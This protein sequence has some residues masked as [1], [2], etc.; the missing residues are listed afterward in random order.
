MILDRDLMNDL[1]IVL[2]FDSKS[3]E[4]D[5]SVVAKREH[6]INM[7]TNSF[8]NNLLLDAIDGSLD[9]NDSTL[10]W[11]NLPTSITKLTTPIQMDINQKLFLHLSMNRPTYRILWIKA[12]IFCHNNANNSITCCR[13]FINCLMVN[14][15]PS[16]ALRSI[17]SKLKILSL[18]VVDFIQCPPAI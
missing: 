6:P 1:G 16:M 8:A 4:W 2:N 17:Y 7:S 13:N 18:S 5:K 3:M 9:N 14:L 10:C 12:L 11:T 15:R